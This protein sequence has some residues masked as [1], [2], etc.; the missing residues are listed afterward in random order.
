MFGGGRGGGDD[1]NIQTLILTHIQAGNKMGKGW[2]K[3]IKSIR[4][5]IDNLFRKKLRYSIP[6]P[7]KQTKKKR[8]N[9]VAV[10]IRRLQGGAWILN[11]EQYPKSLFLKGM[12]K[13]GVFSFFQCSDASDIN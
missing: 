11:R 7:K 13:L 9:V 3:T 6:F 4:R 5:K 12:C 8:S 2:D 1:D 10:I